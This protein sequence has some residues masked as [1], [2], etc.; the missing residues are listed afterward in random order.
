MP[1]NITKDKLDNT[2]IKYSNNYDWPSTATEEDL[3]R[4]KKNILEERDM[5]LEECP[6]YNIEIID[7]SF[8][9]NRDVKIDDLVEDLNK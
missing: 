2:L 4:N 8:D 6:K 9:E 5:Y 3:I 7:T 1:V